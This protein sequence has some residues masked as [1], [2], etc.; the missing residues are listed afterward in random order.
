MITRGIGKGHSIAVE[1]DLQQ[2]ARTEPDVLSETTSLRH[3]VGATPFQS[4]SQTSAQI[5]CLEDIILCL[6]VVGASTIPS[7]ALVKSW[8]RASRS[9]S[10]D[11]RCDGQGMCRNFWL[12][13]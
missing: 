12:A 4:T 13:M 2:L 6:E 11:A 5:L 3:A 7:M 10:E 1:R 9:F 8:R